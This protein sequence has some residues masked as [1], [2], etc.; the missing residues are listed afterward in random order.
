MCQ[1]NATGL[2]KKLQEYFSSVWNIMDVFA[3]VLFFLALGLRSNASTEE[4]SHLVYAIDSWIWIL[5]LL[6]V[7]YADRGLGPYVV[8][9]GKMVWINSLVLFYYFPFVIYFPIFWCMS[10][11]V[12]LNIIKILFLRNKRSYRLPVITI[13]LL[14]LSTYWRK[15]EGKWCENSMVSLSLHSSI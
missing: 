12:S 14:S 9:I 13:N 15:F 6:N 2:L 7:F 5:R 1:S 10:V 11:W 3:V 8:M 4:Y